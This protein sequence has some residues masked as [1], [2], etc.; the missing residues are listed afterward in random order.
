MLTT[1]FG[2]NSPDR[3][4]GAVWPN[5]FHKRVRNVPVPYLVEVFYGGATFRR[6][7]ILATPFD[8][9]NFPGYTKGE[10]TEQSYRLAH[11]CKLAYTPLAEYFDQPSQ[12]GRPHPIKMTI[13]ETY[14]AYKLIALNDQ[15]GLLNYLLVG[16]GLLGK[17]LFS[18]KHLISDKG[19]RQKYLSDLIGQ[20]IG[21]ITLP[22]AIPTRSAVAKFW[23]QWLAKVD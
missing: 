13:Q 19:Q 9:I 4:G 22:F 7:A 17:Q 2:I 12:H 15:L 1:L 10:D 6:E 23:V 5:G 3:F 18:I 8:A 20:G 16:W 14:A 21:A 11:S